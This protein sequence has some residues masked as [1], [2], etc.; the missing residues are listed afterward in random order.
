M[1]EAQINRRKDRIHEIIFE[2][3]TPEGKTFDITLLV[4]IVLSIIAVMLESV[5]SINDKYHH[6]LII[7][8]WVLTIL[9]T[10]EYALRMYCVRSRRKYAFSF[11]GIVDLLSIL[12]TYLSLFVVGPLNQLM[13]IRILRLL[14]I[15]RIFKLGHFMGESA[16]ILNALKASQAKISVFMFFVMVMVILMGSIMHLIEGGVNDG[17]NNIPN[18]IYWAIVTL[19]TVGYGD[20]S[21]ITPI[22]KFLSAIVMILGY[23]VIAVPTGIVSSEMSNKKRKKKNKNKYHNTQVCRFCTKEDHDDDAKYC[24]GCG[25]LLNEPLEE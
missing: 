8:E 5:E 21:P 23:A 15:F 17:F 16:H 6:Q 18:S 19:T 10:I 12:P 14:R 13:I 22:G 25:E 11:F 9:F 4:M 3:D 1:T 20:I 24:N 2:A 7:A